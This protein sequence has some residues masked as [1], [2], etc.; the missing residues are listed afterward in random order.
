MEE[1]RPIM[2]DRL[3]L[4][5]LNLGKLKPSDFTARKGGAVHIKDDARKT[6]LVEYQSMKRKQTVEHTA[7][8]RKVPYGLLPHLQARLLARVLRGDVKTY[9]PCLIRG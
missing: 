8:G 5:L 3:V 4:R 9:I 2:V 6:V 7:T 1:L